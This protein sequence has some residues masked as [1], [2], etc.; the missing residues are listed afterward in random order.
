MLWTNLEIQDDIAGLNVTN[1]SLQSME[2][3][4]LSEGMIHL[5]LANNEFH[6][7]PT[8]LLAPWRILA[9]SHTVRK[10][11]ELRLRLYLFRTIQKKYY[12]HKVSGLPKLVKTR[13]HKTGGCGSTPHGVTWVKEKDIDK[14]KEFDAFISF[15]HKDQDLV[16]PELIEQTE[17]RDPKVKLFIHYKHF[18]PGELI[19]LNIL[20]AIEVSRGLSSCFP[21]TYSYT[22]TRAENE[23]HGD[24]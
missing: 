13:R 9:G 7:P 16:I 19:Q 8:G 22:R 10:P 2:E 20:R 11:L 5:F 3:A 18:L 4:R 17:A 12:D 21:S 1:N 23:M 15:S 6:V 14:D 24:S